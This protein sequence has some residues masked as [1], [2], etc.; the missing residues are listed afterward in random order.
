LPILGGVPAAWNGCMFFFQTML[1]LGYLWAFGIS[2]IKSQKIQQLLQ[3]SLLIVSCVVLPIKLR[4][5]DSGLATE[6]PLMWLFLTAFCSVGLP[7]FLLASLAPMLQSWIAKGGQKINPY[8]L[9]TVS[10]SGSIV[11]L[12][13]FPLLLETMLKNSQQ[14]ML[15]QNVFILN[16]ALI[17][18]SAYLNFKKKANEAISSKAIALPEE[19]IQE[20]N[21][22]NNNTQLKPNER[23]ILYWV[24][25]S[26]IPSSFLLSSTA[27]ITSELAPMPLLW[28]IPLVIYLT[29]FIL[30]FAPKPILLVNKQKAAHIILWLG[31]SIAYFNLNN[32]IAHILILA[33]VLSFGL[34][35]FVSWCL[36][37]LLAQDKPDPKHL[38]KFY[39][40]LALGGVLGGVF[41]SLVAPLVFNSLYEYPLAVILCIV[42]LLQNNLD[43]WQMPILKPPFALSKTEWSKT[44]LFASLPI[45]CIFYVMPK[46]SSEK[47]HT[48]IIEKSRS[49]FGSYAVIARNLTLLPERVKPG[50]CAKYRMLKHG[51]TNHGIQCTEKGRE[52]EPNVYY[53][54]KEPIGELWKI[55][56]KPQN[57]AVIGL[58]SGG[59]AAHSRAGEN[60]DFY[61]IDPNIVR[62]AKT[63]FS[64]LRRSPAKVTVSIGDGRLELA[65]SKNQYDV[66]TIDA[67]NS[68]SIP[69][70]LITKEA[71]QAY[72]KHLSKN[73]LVVMHISNRYL[74][75]A[76]VVQGLAES[77]GFLAFIKK[78]N[79]SHYTVLGSPNNP[80]IMLLEKN[81]WNKIT[82]SRLWTDD[83]CNI[84]TSFIFFH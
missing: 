43:N 62:V 19:P 18:I 60:W 69:M 34:L 11:G 52:M 3:L 45:I 78:T 30:V 31:L 25:L 35:F 36:H 70:H 15:W 73:G 58:G 41:N 12:L 67:F 68:D 82:K 48:K 46:S 63:H 53:S 6:Q 26:F 79:K 76:P 64:F 74:N 71:M 55:M 1:L 80:T 13:A 20:E 33:M 49:F 61:E 4:T 32:L 72:Q 75:L 17:A 56:P 10:N 16:T 14:M 37:S 66:L 42:V 9:Y 28:A 65:K 57:V 81:G 23:K 27:Y 5:V 51:N 22:T 50:E 38:T 40:S 47:A 83:F 54:Y 44:F 7:F 59:M 8:V 21:Q 39:L 77:C 2:K 29:S 24:L 84:L